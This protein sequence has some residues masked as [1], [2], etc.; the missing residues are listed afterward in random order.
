MNSI[1]K[2]RKKDFGTDNISGYITIAPW[3]IGFFVFTI[4][5]L[6]SS[7]YYSF[8]QFNL[9]DA[10]FWIGLENYKAVFADPRVWHSLKIT[11]TYALVHVP[12]KLLFALCVA[13]LF[14]LKHR[15]VGLYRTLYYLPSIIGGSIAV[16]VMWIYMFGANGPFNDILGLFGIE[17]T[18]SW[19][20]SPDTALWMIIVLAV[21]QFGSPM[22]IFLAGLKQ[23]PQTYYEAAQI[24]GAGAFRR[25]FAITLPSLSPVIFF[26]LLMQLISAFMAFTQTYIISNGTGGPSDST[27][28]YALY[29]Y[30]QGMKY[31]K[32]GYACALAWVMV[33]IIAIVTA[34]IFK[35]SNN[36][37]FYE[38]E[39]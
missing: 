37:V 8:T 18:K 1:H 34:I 4:Y 31:Q 32:M 21:W 12:L 5:P 36:W 6:L 25:F 24:D 19:I 7:L 26:N 27:L 15:G 20:G 17:T 38:D 13:M 30:L 9:L 3:L 29:I 10:P 33:V 23:I 16:S 39:T 35:T 28:F 11:F 2:S 22:L 14:N